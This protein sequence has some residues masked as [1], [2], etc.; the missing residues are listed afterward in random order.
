MIAATF[1]LFNQVNRKRIVPNK[2]DIIIAM[3][4]CR[5][6][7]VGEYFFV[8]A[9]TINLF[10]KSELFDRCPWRV[11]RFSIEVMMTEIMP[12]ASARSMPWYPRNL[13]ADWEFPREN[14]P[15]RS[16]RVCS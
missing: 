16:A 4:Q 13:G 7:Y 12:G 9:I 10:L 14:K 6:R 3:L 5:M 8:Y 1:A 2:S 15:R 11:Y